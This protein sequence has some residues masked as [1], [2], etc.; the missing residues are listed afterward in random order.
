[1][2]GENLAATL[3]NLVPTLAQVPHRRFVLFGEVPL[4][5]W[6]THAGSP[7]HPDELRNKAEVACLASK[8]PRILTIVLQCAPQGGIAH[9]SS[10]EFRAP[11]ML[12]LNYPRLVEEAKEEAKR[13]AAI[14]PKK[15]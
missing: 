12:Q 9:A 2:A 11:S 3:S 13:A 5:F 15:R 7:P 6:L 10:A 1:M 8:V 14:P 4:Q